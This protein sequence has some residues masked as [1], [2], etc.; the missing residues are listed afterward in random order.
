MVA[1][2]NVLAERPV[3]YSLI[4]L[5]VAG[6]ALLGLTKTALPLI[7]GR[8][9]EEESRKK[10]KDYRAIR[11]TDRS[12]DVELLVSHRR[13]ASSKD[14]DDATPGDG[15][16]KDK[17]VL[18]VVALCIALRVGLSKKIF[19][20][21]QCT[22]NN[23]EVRH[24]LRR[25][26]VRPLTSG[27]KLAL[28][29]IFAVYDYTH[30]LACKKTADDERD[31]ISN[32]AFEDFRDF[33]RWANIRYLPLSLALSWSIYLTGPPGHASTAMCVGISGQ[34]T[35]ANVLQLAALCLD[36]A[37]ITLGSRA[38]VA[39]ADDR[40]RVEVLGRISFASVILLCIGAII[41]LLF[42][43]NSVADTLT[44]TSSLKINAFF[45]G[46]ALALLSLCLSYIIKDLRPLALVFIG[47]FTSV[48]FPMLLWILEDRKP[49]PPHNHG[50]KVFGL[51]IA[52]VTFLAF[53]N[54]YRAS[55]LKDA[56]GNILKRIHKRI[57]LLLMGGMIFGI[58]AAIIRSR[59]VG[60]HSPYQTNRAISFSCSTPMSLLS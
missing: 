51:I 27:Q 54:T 22:V 43:L 5:F 59:Y 28:P 6:A 38:V 34:H 23:L 10:G 41:G 35:I 3:Q 45:D 40:S 9:S 36:V 4:T 19:E 25:L 30:G 8:S 14:D 52:C 12:D 17:L 32:T 18:A 46:L 37:I 39:A 15:S 48:F 20:I 21:P 44:T 13:T 49:F 31:S 26:R 24:P 42:D 47:T 16:R 53:L 50:R 60:K 2:T 56:P 7:I 29:I 1:F 55:E 58:A 57:Y 11:G 33:F